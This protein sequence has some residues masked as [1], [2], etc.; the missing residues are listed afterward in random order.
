M[1]LRR[2]LLVERL[3][4]PADRI[5]ESLAA[6]ARRLLNDMGLWSDFLA[7]GHS[8]WFAARS[9]WGT[10]TPTERDSLAD[11]DGNGWHLDRRRFEARL[12]S[13]AVARG[14]ALLA[15]ARP[16]DLRPSPAGWKLTL[17]YRD[18]A[19]T[20][21]ARMILDFAG[22]ASRILTPFGARRQVRD[23]LICGWL[24]GS[25]APGCTGGGVSY[26]ESA[27]D[28]WWYTAP[29]TG[30][31]RVLAWHTDADLPSAAILRTRS[32][33]LEKAS[34]SPTL[35]AEIADACFDDSSPPRVAAANSSTLMPP[36]SDRWIAA[37]DAALSFDPLSSQGLFHALY[38]GLAAAQA[39]DHALS[40]DDSALSAYA[41]SL[42]RIDTAYRRNLTAWYR[43]EHRWPNQE[44]WRRR[45]G[46][47]R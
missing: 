36:A 45:S 38:T 22:R 8:P 1:P 28:G 13:T 17:K 4:E 25:L 2:V 11:L 10:A 35:M 3:V 40:G 7:D 5:G 44:F 47:A 42:V 12:R 23:R 33:L 21:E 32:A 46:P 43:L 19:L 27:P 15:P 16:I 31:R 9:V 26:T 41:E 37:G 18:H 14:A 34:T 39:V 20:V 29:L 6:A 30:G 24:R